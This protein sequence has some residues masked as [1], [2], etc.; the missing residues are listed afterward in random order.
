MKKKD[1]TKKKSYQG[2]NY[3][4]NYRIKIR[5]RQYVCGNT[6]LLVALGGKLAE[7][8]WEE[9]INNKIEKPKYWDVVIQHPEVYRKKTAEE[10]ASVYSKEAMKAISAFPRM[11]DESENIIIPHRWIRSN[12]NKAGTQLGVYQTFRSA[13]LKDTVSKFSRISNLK[14]SDDFID[15]GTTKPEE[16]LI[17]PGQVSGSNGVHSIVSKHEAFYQLEF[18]FG[19]GVFE[20]RANRIDNFDALVVDLFRVGQEIGLGGARTFHGKYNVLNLAQV[21]QDGSEVELYSF[22][23]EYAKAA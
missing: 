17:I 10:Y 1:E 19:Y 5:F 22:E 6:P 9:M 11:S 21:N 14:N 12:L 15:L 8:W 2:G 13:G 16:Y 20:Q 4:R 23:E 18:E 7:E 3:F